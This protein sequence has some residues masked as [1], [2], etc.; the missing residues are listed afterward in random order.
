MIIGRLYK[1]MLFEDLEPPVVDL[2][3]SPPEFI[4]ST[5]EVTVDWD[6]PLFHDNSRE[7]LLITQSHTFGRFP[8]GTTLVTYTAT[9]SSGN[10]ASCSINIT[11][12]S[13]LDIT[14][15][16]LCSMSLGFDL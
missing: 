3:E 10:T 15:F 6:E 9:D 13:K 12:Q 11:L 8:F 16:L 2:C 4:T 5:A 1:K 14:N 7:E